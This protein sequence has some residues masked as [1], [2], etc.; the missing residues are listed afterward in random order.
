MAIDQASQTQPAAATAAADL[1]LRTSEEI[2]GNILAGFRKDFQTMIF[3]RFP[4]APRGRSYLLELLPR[5]AKTSEVT[6]FN[7]RFSQ[8]R[9]QS[10]GNDPSMKA[11]WI[12]VALTSAGLL[13]LAP[14]VRDD[15]QNFAAFIEG[16]AAHAQ[17]LGDT[18]LSAPE[19]WVVGGPRQQAVDVLLTVAADDPNDLLV[20]LD[21]QRA[22]ATRHGLLTIFE[23]R[24]ETLPGDRAG[25][26]HFGF[27]DGIS[28]PGVRGY[29]TPDPRNP[30][31]VKGHPGS[32]LIQ[33]GEFVLGYPR[34]G[35]PSGDPTRPAPP[36]EPRPHAPWMKDGSFQVFRRLQ[37]DVPGFWAQVTRRVQSLPS[38]DPMREDLLAAKLVGRWRSGTPLVFAPEDDNRDPRN[39]RQDNDF[40]YVEDQQGHQCPHFAHIRKMYPRDDQSFGDERRRIMR[41]GIPFGLPFDPAAG[42]G[43]GVDAQRGLLFMAFMSDI[44]EQFEFLQSAWANDV[45]FPFNTATP[46]PD[47]IIGDAQPRPKPV[48]LHRRNRPDLS[49]D[50][51]RFVHTTG[52]VYAFAPSLST[53][54]KLANN[55]RLKDQPAPDPNVLRVG[56][57]AWITRQGGQAWRLR[58]QPGLQRTT[59]VGL[60]QP[61]TQ[62]TL[63]EGPRPLDGFKW[64]RV[65]TKDGRTGWV[66]EDG[67]RP[68]PD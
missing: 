19:R 56:G 14:E 24:G 32:D 48:L 3:L 67:L 7:E 31:Q 66:A 63:L 6:A 59:I 54:R 65:R 42:R 36:D 33:P 34:Q 27:K 61:G 30:N 22:L 51:A 68:R 13:K 41:R 60:L 25:H 1:P 45:N 5:I 40:D 17:A 29:D 64:W 58:S 43:H 57:Q 52:A 50:F 26:E 35:N 55:Q 12:N 37:Q 38:D 15:L 21:K 23:Q 18:G 10:G 8:A 11:T 4:D 53:L 62:M 16:P 28:Q 2:Q 20:Q 49:L 46:G 39:P 9:Q 44:G 47:P